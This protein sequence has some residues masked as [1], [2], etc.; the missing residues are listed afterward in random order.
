L[1]T[2]EVYGD[3]DLKLDFMMAEGSNSGIFFQGRYE[4]QLCDSWGAQVVTSGENGGIYERWDENRPQGQ[5]GF[6]GYAPRQNVS[7]GTGLWQHLEVSFQA[8]RFD[9]EGKKMENARF[10]KVVLNGVT[11]HE[12]VELFGPTKGAMDTEEKAT[13]KIHFQGDHGAVAFRNMEV[14]NFNKPRPVLKDV[15]YAVYG[16]SYNKIPSFEGIDPELEG[17]SEVLS[18]D[19]KTKSKQ[20]LVR[21]SGNLQINVSGEYLFGLRSVGGFGILRLNGKEVISQNN[22]SGSLELEQGTV[23]FELIYSKFQDWANPGLALTVSGPGIREYQL[24]KGEVAGRDPVDPILVD[25]TKNT[26]LRSFMDLPGN[27]GSE[28]YR[29]T[30]S[31]NIGAPEKVHYT[32]DMDFG[33]IVQVWRG[34][35][36]DATPMWYNRGDGSSRPMGTVQYFGLPT[37]SVSQLKDIGS[38]WP[39]DTTGTKFRQKGYLLDGSERPTFVYSIHG[40][41]VQDVIRPMENGHGLERT[42]EIQN[43]LDDLYFRLACANTIEMVSKDLYIIGD[44]EYYLKIENTDG[45]KPII[46]SIDGKKEL[47]LPLRNKLV[48]AILF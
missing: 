10:L 38:A 20:F 22:R 6:Q 44:K 1:S 8:P 18:S 24:T 15:Q 12:N 28:D 27:G 14:N 5:K 34:D 45:E 46:R 19:L 7:K 30:H 26:L 41:E 25:A 48:Y 29:V 21:Y 31:V 23:A 43:R 35:F 37:S 2:L 16:G 40:A 33:N 42:I 9:G 32:Y 3:M 47:L 11:I 36:L 13:G 4:L 17:P 39:R